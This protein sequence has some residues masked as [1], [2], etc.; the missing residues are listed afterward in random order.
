MPPTGTMAIQP[1]SQKDQ[2]YKGT[3]IPK[4]IPV[5]IHSIVD[6]SAKYASSGINMIGKRHR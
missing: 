3:N 1:R 5:A 4:A 6:V 2:K